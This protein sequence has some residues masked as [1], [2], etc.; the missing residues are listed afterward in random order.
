M[1]KYESPHHCLIIEGRCQFDRLLVILLT[2]KK[3][4][5][6]PVCWQNRKFR[7][8]AEYSARVFYIKCITNEIL[9]ETMLNRNL[10]R[11]GT[12]W[13]FQIDHQA[14]WK[15]GNWYLKVNIIKC[16]KTLNIS[17]PRLQF[18]GY[19]QVYIVIFWV[20]LH[21]PITILTEGYLIA[22]GRRYESIRSPCLFSVHMR[23]VSD[24]T[25]KSRVGCYVG[26]A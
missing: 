8:G 16:K 11:S 13:P 21:N 19:F 10:P 17:S 3:N 6:W 4:Y 26:I 24:V 2:I 1:H 22:N 20:K 15:I 25:V 9:F 23:D 5:S 18:A 14:L 7:G 12:W